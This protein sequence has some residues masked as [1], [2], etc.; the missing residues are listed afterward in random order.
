MT[1][2]SFGEYEV[3]EHG[4]LSIWPEILK[5]DQVVTRTYAW[6]KDRQERHANA[7]NLAIKIAQLLADADK[8]PITKMPRKSKNAK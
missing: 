6:N 8:P 1:V 2:Y 3:H 5:D 4:N 7:I